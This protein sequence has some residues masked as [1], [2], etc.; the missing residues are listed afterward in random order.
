MDRNEYVLQVDEDPFLRNLDWLRVIAIALILLGLTALYAPFYS[1]FG[2]GRIFGLL[3]LAGGAMFVVH[4]VRSRRWGGFSAE[5]LLGVLYIATG[6]LVF[7][8]P[9]ELVPSLTLFLGVFY[10]AKGILKMGYS[11]RLQARSSWQWMLAN[12]TVSVLMGIVV[13]AGLPSVAMWGVAILVG[14]DLIFSGLTIFLFAHAMHAVVE[15]GNI[16][17]IGTNCFQGA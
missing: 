10:L 14:L 3:F 12:G 4:A 6:I 11:L 5:F 9:L 15:G 7:F 8:H 16:F 17:C 1:S 2:P 13:L